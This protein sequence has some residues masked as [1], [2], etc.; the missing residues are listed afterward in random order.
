MVMSIVGSL[1]FLYA[2]TSIVALIV[3]ICIYISEVQDYYSN[4]EDRK[5]YARSIIFFPIYPLFYVFVLVSEVLK[6][7]EMVSR[8]PRWKK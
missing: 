3:N 4:Q 6:D 1:I 2:M 8:K 5:K 7:A